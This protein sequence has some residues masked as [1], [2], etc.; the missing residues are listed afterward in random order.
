V[1]LV[2][3]NPLRAFIYK[4]GMARFA[5]EPYTSPTGNN[6]KNLYMHLTNYAINKN[7][8]D[9]EDGD[10]TNCGHK[11]YMSYI[12]D[13][14]RENEG[15]NNIWEKIKDIINK[16]LITVQPSLA[17]AYKTS[18]PHDVENC[19]CFEIL[20]FDVMLDHKL[21]PWLLEVNHSPSFHTDSDLDYDLKYDLIRETINL[22]GLNPSRK[23]K[24]KRCRQKELNERM[25]GKSKNVQSIVAEKKIK[26]TKA[27]IKRHKH[28][29]NNLGNYEILFPSANPE[30]NK[31]YDRYAEEALK[32][33]EKFTGSYKPIQKAE[34]PKIKKKLKKGSSTLTTSTR[35]TKKNSLRLSLGRP[36]QSK[37][38]K[39]LYLRKDK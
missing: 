16:A 27:E 22:L 24:Y 19:T 18:R 17:H 29:E 14:I 38:N 34:T 31:K 39:R 3:V 11:R 37:E 28:E 23:S 12:F 33:W 9:Y 10:D 26:R 2:G 20:G 6:L 32:I 5:T 1:L 8:E 7:H 30:D 35:D 4:E 25:M 15:E 21:R 36:V 13:Y